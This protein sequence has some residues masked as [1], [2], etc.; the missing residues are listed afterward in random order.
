MIFSSFY[1]GWSELVTGYFVFFFCESAL[2]AST[3]C[4][5]NLIFS[6]RGAYLKLGANSSIYGKYKNSG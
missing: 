1:M 6:K 3:V 4:I 5:I 2:T